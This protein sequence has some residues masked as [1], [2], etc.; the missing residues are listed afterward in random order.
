SENGDR[1]PGAE[2]YPSVEYYSGDPITLLWPSVGQGFQSLMGMLF[3]LKY[4]ELGVILHENAPSIQGSQTRV[5]GFGAAIDLS[6]LIP[7]SVDKQLILDSGGKTKSIL[8]SSWDAADHNAISF[9]PDEIRALN[10][11][12]NYRLDT[13]KTDAT[14]ADV[15]GAN[16]SDMTVDETPGYN[17]AYIVIDDVLFGGEYLGVNM[18][19]GLGIPPYISGMPALE[20][21]LEIRTVGDWAFSVDGQCHFMSFSLSAGISFRS[22]NNIPIPDRLNFFLG[23]ITPGINVDGVGVLWLQGAGGGIENLYDT[24]FMTDS[25]PPLKLIIAAQFSILQLFSATASL[26]LSLRGIDVSLTNG[27]FREVVDETTGVVTRPQPI[28]IDAGI[29]LDWYPEVYFEGVV[30]LALAMVITG[31]GYVVADTDSYEIFLR[32][33]VQIP[34]DV[35][36][37]GGIS[38][39]DVNMGV[40]ETKVWGQAEWLQQVIGLTYYWGGDIDWNRG[41][42]VYPTYPELWEWSRRV[43][44]VP[45]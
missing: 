19:L 6:F 4:G 38:L 11:R 31:G 17:A 10:K 39:T 7:S 41:S 37:L 3:S 20:G 27:Q 34:T 30:N 28:T 8:G 18:A 12:A 14:A 40:N 36:L 43:L 15:N 13:A 16:Y 1:N 25:I 21:L 23:G 35:P 32:A 2:K 29:R 45:W 9:T 42:K 24:I 5:V 33:G 44:P 22:K 26:G